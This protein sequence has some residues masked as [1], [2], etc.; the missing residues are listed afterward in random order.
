MNSVIIRYVEK[1][2]SNVMVIKYA[3]TN[4]EKVAVS[5]VVVLKY[6][7]MVIINIIV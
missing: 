2:V 4:Y 6:V 5:N 7:F 1:Y 3:L